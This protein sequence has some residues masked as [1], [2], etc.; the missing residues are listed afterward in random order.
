VG[1]AAESR[2]DFVP[3]SR[4]SVREK[5]FAF[6]EARPSGA[7]AA[8]L[9]GLLF[10]GAGSD[11][12]LAPRIVR[13]L[14]GGDPNFTFDSLSSL[15]SVRKNDSLKIPIDEARYV[16]VDL[17]TTGGRAGPGAIT[18]IGAYRMD[19]MRIAGS[20]QTLVRP[21][22]RIPRFVTALTSITNEMVADAP[23][24]EAVL[25]GFRDFLG[26]AVMVAHNAQFDFAFLDFEF[27]R[28][29]G[30]GLTNPVLCTIR[31]AR[32]FLPSVKRR[33]LDAM[34]EHFGLSTEGRHRG[35]GD[36]RMAAELLS[37]LLELARQ[38][39]VNRLDLLLDWQHRGAA[40]RRI[41]R[42]VPPEEIAAI[43]QAPGVYL[44]RNA[45][46][47]LLYVG[48]AKRLRDRVSSY[49]NGGLGLK[50][51]TIELVGHVWS[52]ETRLTRSPLEAAMLEARLIRELKPPYNRMLKGAAPSYFLRIDLMDAFPRLVVA[53]RM[54]ARRGVMQI[55]PFIGRRSLDQAVRALARILGLRTCADKIAPDA[56]F[57]PCIYGQMGHC[58]RPCNAT[59]DEDGYGARVRRAVEFLRGRAGPIMGQLAAARDQ[60]AAAMRFEEASRA[61]RDLEALATLSARAS[62]LSRIVTENNLVIVTG[63]QNDLDRAA[64]VVL[65]GR[66]ALTRAN[67]DSLE[68][69]AEIAAFVADNYERY[70]SKPVARDE[71]EAMTMVARW[72]RE[73]DP[74]DG[75]LIYLTG[76]R[77]DAAALLA[78]SVSVPSFHQAVRQ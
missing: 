76:P 42:H 20:F 51:K 17:E 14:L 1:A 66:L 22:M 25:P 19:G 61:R 7:P 58:A 31:L 4:A 52:I 36:A 18:E 35:L 2:S 8:E 68:I 23:P 74:D 32:R 9:A 46:G 33:R 43:A 30:I 53:G 50:A 55:G 56:N 13:H 60:A 63:S 5:L 47:D 64:Y 24:I 16:V 72:L 45:R 67:P 10:S 12:E 6:L 3:G 11:P 41:E 26:D 38:S 57:S 77:I 29:F 73:R 54:T 59:V 70:R 44:M 78:A 37:I 39:G 15:W 27:R 71:L 28:V 34:A 40:G 62:R 65:S 49:F 48:K 69:A 75:R 21:Q